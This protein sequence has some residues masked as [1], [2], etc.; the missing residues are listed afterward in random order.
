MPSNPSSSTWIP[1]PASGGYY[2]ACGA[3][4]IVAS[5]T[6]LTGS[7]GVIMQSLNYRELFEKVGL[8][9]ETF[10]SGAFK[11]TLSG[12][13]EMREDEREYVQSLVMEMYER[14]VGIVAEARALDVRSTEGRRSRWASGDWRAGFG[15]PGWWIPQGIFKM[16]MHW[17]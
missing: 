3:R 17:P 12:S 16:L 9:A 8:Q 14:F 5:H 1:W 15:A 4:K 6:T 2:I 7:I 10:R 11:D 13:R